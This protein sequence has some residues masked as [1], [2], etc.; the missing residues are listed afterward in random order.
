MVSKAKKISYKKLKKLDE[1]YTQRDTD[2]PDADTRDI[3]RNLVC[4]HKAILL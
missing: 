2:N 4:A 3:E 1:Q